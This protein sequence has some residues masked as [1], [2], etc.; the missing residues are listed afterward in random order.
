MSA[1]LKFVIFNA[2][3]FGYS[4]GVNRGIAEAHERGVVTSAT[5]MVNTPATREAVE[6]SRRL[7]RLAVGLHVNFTNEAQRLIDLDDREACRA[8]LWRQYATFCDLLGRKPTHLDAHQ[9]VHRHPMRLGLFEE[10]AD[11]VGLPLRDRAPVTFKGGFYG[12]WEPGVFD[13]SKVSFE[14]LAGILRHEVFE[15]VFELACHPG[16]FDPSLEAVY[17]REREPELRTLTDPR[18]RALI[19][20]LDLRLISY[21]ELPAAV[22]ELRS[23]RPSALGPAA[24]AARTGGRFVIFNAEDFGYSRGINRGI[25]EAHERGVVSSASLIVNAPAAPEAVALA[26]EL[27]RLAVGLDVNFTDEGRARID[28][29]DPAACRAEL[30]SQ[31]ARFCDLLGRQ[32]THLDSHHHVHRHPVRR[33]L[34][35]ELADT[36]GL[37]LRDRPPV[38]F[39]GGFYG[40]WEHGVFDPEKVSLAALEGILRHEIGE[41][42]YELACH[43]GYFDPAL[44][45]VYHREREH[46]LRTL[47]D[48]RLP[49]LLRELGLRAISFAELPAVLRELG[50]EAQGSHVR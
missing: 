27:P 3:D 32:P 23:R 25:R 21:A 22:A 4:R 7:P 26:R 16:Y 41:G 42:V 18:V 19:G 5:L 10:L 11:A 14:A 20:E 36:F 38:V 45:A 35:E 31:H 43:P 40:Q 17:H 9:H 2:D 47:L 37:P 34:F 33:R 8:E 24:G 48:P 29:E 30:W 49:A 46:E 44:E 13:P 39:K 1:G 50:A 12:Q 6:L 15:G 28:L